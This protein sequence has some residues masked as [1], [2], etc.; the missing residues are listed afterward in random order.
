MYNSVTYNVND[1]NKLKTEI[2]DNIKELCAKNKCGGLHKFTVADV[3]NAISGMKRNKIDSD[4]EYNSNHFIYGTHRLVVSLMILF[5]GMLVH[6][7]SPSEFLKAVVIPIPK[8]K[9]KSLNNSDNY[10]GIALGNIT[11]QIM[12]IMI[13]DCS[14]NIKKGHSTMQC[15]FVVN[16]VIQYYRNKNSDV[17]VMLL[18]ASKAFDKVHY[19]KLFNLLCKRGLCPV[20][21]RL[22]LYVYTNQTISVKWGS[23][24]SC[25]VSISNGVKQGGILSPVLFIIYID[26]LF[27]ML[28][29]SGLG[30]HIGTNFM[31]AVGYADDIA[32]IAP[33]VMSLKKMLHICDRFGGS[34]D[35]T[36]NVSKYQLI[37]YSNYRDEFNDINHND[38]FIKKSDFACHL[39]NVIGP[40]PDKL[41]DL[42]INKFI[43]MF[44]WV[45]CNV[46]KSL[47]EC[48]ISFI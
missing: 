27:T 16:E 45:E 31:G 26:V 7:F 19:M 46:Q 36:F 14:K 4:G 10:R 34:Y 17:Y 32:L 28:K 8:N 44:Q 39:G 2:I 48:E 12:D 9:K 38:F 33:S 41:Y 3:K 30:C 13:M 23:Q 5:N 18:D 42:V 11:G 35:V 43:T 20:I 1:C 25:N 21:C 6:G 15:T 37:H 29:D 47:C 24:H 40:N 22:L